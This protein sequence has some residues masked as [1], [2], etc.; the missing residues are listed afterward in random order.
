MDLIALLKLSLVLYSPQPLQCHLVQ[1]LT[2]SPSH[3]FA[4][5]LVFLLMV[6]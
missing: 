4:Q 5:C 1:R 3:L 2:L 6:N